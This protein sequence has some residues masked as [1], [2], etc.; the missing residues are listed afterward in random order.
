MYLQKRHICWIVCWFIVA[1][2]IYTLSSAYDEMLN[3]EEL[4]SAE[5]V[6][7]DAK[8][9]V[10][11]DMDISSAFK[12]ISAEA[13]IDIV[14]DPD[15]EEKVDFKVEDKTWKQVFD[16]ICKMYKLDA[17]KESGYIYVMTIAEKKSLEENLA[18]MGTEV[19]EVNNINAAEMR[20]NLADMS[21]SR[22]RIT[23]VNHN[24]S[25]IIY[26]IKDN[27]EKMKSMIHRLDVEVDQISISAKI[28]EVSSGTLQNLGIQ[29][30]F[31]GSLGAKDASGVHLPGEE[32]VAGASE[33]LSYGILSSDNFA[34][35]LEYVFSD[36][37]S[38]VVAQPSITTI[39]NKPADIIMSE[40][41]RTQTSNS[42]GTSISYQEAET[43]LEVKPHVT[44]DK[45][46]MM[47]VVAKKESPDANGN[48]KSQS[49]NTNLVVNDGETVVIAGMTS[50][51]KNEGETGVPVLKNIPVIGNLFK[52][53][54]KSY[55]KSD[56]LFFVTPH[57]IKRQ[58]NNQE[59]NEG[60]SEDQ[61]AAEARSSKE[62]ASEE[63][64]AEQEGEFV[65]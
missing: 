62:A 21:S 55:S 2:G 36:N 57:I 13:G 27:I 3:E 4:G 11:K 53:S 14:V 39:D 31:F 64:A 50:N 45:R 26:D 58:I 47:K 10:F 40:M 1:G 23:V 65:E 61:G 6:E 52:R 20:Q 48:I 63:G 30:G 5:I 56:L 54:N 25:L 28:V 49:A 41:V 44:E 29:W 32:V 59:S 22:G 15:I 38:E 18:P 46:I 34:A 37:Q 12:M 19:V 51:Q 33:S 7:E 9:W 8:K 24:N 43:G 16:I 17:S 42:Y 60:E 35:T